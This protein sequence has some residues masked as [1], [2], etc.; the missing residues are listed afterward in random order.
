MHECVRCIRE[1]CGLVEKSPPQQQNLQIHAFFYLTFSVHTY[2]WTLWPNATHMRVADDD[3]TE[4]ICGHILWLL[5][6]RRLRPHADHYA[7]RQHRV[8]QRLPGLWME[9]GLE[10]QF[11][12]TFGIFEFL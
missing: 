10:Q 7:G 9:Q 6:R 8:K 2:R 1:P 11:K 4:R 12:Y 5:L 3:T